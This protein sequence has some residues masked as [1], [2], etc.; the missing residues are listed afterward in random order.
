[1]KSKAVI[2]SLA[3]W[4]AVLGFTRLAAGAEDHPP[5]YIYGRWVVKR[6][7]TPAGSITYGPREL[8]AFIGTVAIYSAS[9]VRVRVPPP[10]E[11]YGIENF[12]VEHPRYRFHRQSAH[13]FFLE[14]HSG[15]REIGI[16]GDSV[17][18]IEIR[19]ADGSDVTRPGAIIFIQDKNY[20]VTGWGGGYFE[21]V[22]QK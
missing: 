9:K 12:V 1:M 10:M 2:L 21:M 19:H 14:S 18:I 8:D 6:D 15:L 20:I 13:E 5:S 17:E 11:K 7:V 16:R 3:L 4:L 22:R